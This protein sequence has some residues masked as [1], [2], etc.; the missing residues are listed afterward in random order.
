L[1]NVF[2]D[3]KEVFVQVSE[4]NGY[5][6]SLNDKLFNSKH[7]LLVDIKAEYKP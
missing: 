5:K 7:P 4:E 3:K 1:A 2:E 6:I